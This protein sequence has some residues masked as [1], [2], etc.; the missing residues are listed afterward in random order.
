MLK[1]LT[2]E[3]I[4]QTLKDVIVF[5]AA[6]GFR[7]RNRKPFEK[8]SEPIPL[9]YFRGD[10]DV[11]IMSVIAIKDHEDPKMLAPSNEAD[12]VRCFEEY[13]NGGLEIM[14]HQIW[15]PRLDWSQGLLSLIH[16][17]DSDKTILEDITEL[18]NRSV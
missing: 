8:S 13:A 2:D 16:R 6:L 5:A 4:F 15:D 7:R 9:E 3:R 10:F 1:E 12:R 18:A 11:T 17:E 14:K